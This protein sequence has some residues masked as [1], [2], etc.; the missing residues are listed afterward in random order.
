MQ[1]YIK[2][3][4]IIIDMSVK[5]RLIEFAKA[6]ERSV[7]AF[8]IKVGLTIGYINTIRVS[9]QPDK[10]QS[11][12][13]HYPDLNAE[14]LLTG[15]GS[16]L[17][18]GTNV[19]PDNCSSRG[20]AKPFIE[21]YGTLGLPN[22]FSTAIKEIECDM[23]SIPFTSNY[24]FSIRGWGDSM[25]NRKNPERSIY[26]GDILACKLWRNHT[27]L[28]WG[29]LY[30]LSTTDGVIIKQIQESDKKGCIKCVSFNEEDGYLPYDVAIEDIHDWALVVHILH[31]SKW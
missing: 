15:K 14:W 26:N 11:I 2:K 10:I 18:A 24:D 22:G 9:I 8:E 28:R 5:Q 16:M 4:K 20:E 1:N 17:K 21:I 23:I 13:S 31:I 30:V 29:Q 6:K 3:I 19:L 27:H 12:V 7:R 25:I